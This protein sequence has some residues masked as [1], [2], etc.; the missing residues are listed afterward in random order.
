MKKVTVQ[1]KFPD[2][3]TNGYAVETSTT[4]EATTFKAAIS[5]AIGQALKAPELKR[6]R[7]RQAIFE[8]TVQ[9]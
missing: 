1:A 8:V 2:V 6:K 4:A 9:E 5:R 3:T 7:I